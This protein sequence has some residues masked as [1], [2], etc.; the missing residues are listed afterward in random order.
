MVYRFSVRHRSCTA[1]MR[2][3]ARMHGSRRDASHW[4]SASFVH[5]HAASFKQWLGEM[6]V[7]ECHS[8]CVCS[9][10]EVNI[11]SVEDETWTT[12][13][14]MRGQAPQSPSILPR[15][16]HHWESSIEWNLPAQ[17]WHSEIHNHNHC[18]VHK[19]DTDWIHIVPAR[20]VIPNHGMLQRACCRRN[21]STQRQPIMNRH[22]S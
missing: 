6:L 22:V 19:H 3:T 10:V 20:S 14:T 12:D 8:V 2:N 4:P 13:V 11:R 1:G 17:S 21:K 16:W 7:R 5:A 9:P 18:H 15:R